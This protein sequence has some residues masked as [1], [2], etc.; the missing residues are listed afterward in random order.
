MKNGYTSESF[1]STLLILHDEDFSLHVYYLTITKINFCISTHFLIKCN[2]CGGRIRAV[3]LSYF[4]FI[5]KQYP[6]GTILL[7]YCTLQILFEKL[8]FCTVPFALA[9]RMVRLQYLEICACVLYF[10][11]FNLQILGNFQLANKETVFVYLNF[12]L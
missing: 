6:Q 7:Q 8:M 9:Q 11:F 1:C 2:T 3:K 4:S 5:F 12:T 10:C